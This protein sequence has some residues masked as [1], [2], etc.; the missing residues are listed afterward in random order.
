M[1][2]YVTVSQIPR[3]DEWVYSYD[4]RYDALWVERIPRDFPQTTLQGAYNLIVKIDAA[5]IVSYFETVTVASPTYWKATSSLELP[6]PVVGQLLLTQDID[7]GQTQS[8][9][10]NRDYSVFYTRLGEP[11]DS[12]KLKHVAIGQQIIVDVTQDGML[13]GVWM[14]DLPP[15]IRKNHAM[16]QSM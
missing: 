10:T 1:T 15:E 6:K 3:S 7:D 13:A 16:K 2:I 14:L 11:V 9:F 4:D 5:K 12:T 8:Y